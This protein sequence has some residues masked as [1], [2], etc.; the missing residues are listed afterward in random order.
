MST[1]FLLSLSA[2]GGISMAFAVS[3]ASA[4][5]SVSVLGV[6]P[7]EHC[8]AAAATAG[9]TGTAGLTSLE[10]C[11]EAVASRDLV[12]QEVGV[13]RLNR[14]VVHLARA[15]YEAAISDFSAAIKDGVNP[16]IALNDRGAAESAL[17]Q[18]VAAQADFTQALEQKP[19]H[20]ETVY[21]NRALTYED[22]GDLKHAYQDYRKAAAANPTW[23]KP[24]KELAR[25]TVSRPSMS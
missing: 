3:T 12:Q 7:A 10:V 20:P 13:A 15:E 6:T 23:D 25:F 9:K 8:A 18:Y 11:N 16:A 14:G 5:E 17:H 2:L 19:E 21:F 1:K 4:Q 22:Q 24:T